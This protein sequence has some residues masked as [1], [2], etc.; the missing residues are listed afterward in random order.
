[1][2][3]KKAA[4]LE[5]NCPCCGARLTIDPALGR[6]IYSTE[7]VKTPADRDLDHAAELLKRDAARRD[8]LFQQS[9]ADEKVK[10]DVLDRKF[11]EALKKSQGEPVERPLR[12]LDLD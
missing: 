7:A 10:S 6:V 2:G 9:V 12:D 5:V 1:M 3:S 8:L 11:Q 4:N